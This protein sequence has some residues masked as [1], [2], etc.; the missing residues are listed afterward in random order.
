M[1]RYEN[2]EYLNL[3]YG[4]IPIILLMVYFRNWK[5]KALKNFGKELSKHGL[6]STFSKVREN[7]KFALLI[8]CISSLIIGIS[9]PQIGTKMEEVKREGVDLMIALDLSF[10]QERL[11]YSYPSQLIIRQQNYF[12]LP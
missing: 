12:Y 9:N 7:I 3:L 10:L 5:S 11:M 6:I 8:F 2:I 1:L 4:L